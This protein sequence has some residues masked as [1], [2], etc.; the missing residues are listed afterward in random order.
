MTIFLKFSLNPWLQDDE[1]NYRRDLGDVVLIYRPGSHQLIVEAV[2]S[3]Q[4]KAEA[5]ASAEAG[6]F[7]VGEVEAEAVGRYYDDGWGGRTEAHAREQAQSQAEHKL[8]EAVDALHRRRHA[9][10]IEAAEATARAEAEIRA[11]EKL[12]ELRTKTRE[13]LR[14]RIQVIIANAE[15][16][17]YHCMNRIVGE[18]YRRTLIELAVQNGGRILADQR[19]GSVYNLELEF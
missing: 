15:E 8:E 13:A 5:Q 6:G 18:A 1:G 10:E 12:E 3:E 2:L 17:V 16:R 14:E 4:I 9:A 7:T 19:S 11:N